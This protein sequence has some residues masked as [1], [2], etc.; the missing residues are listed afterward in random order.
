MKKIIIILAVFSILTVITQI[1]GIVYLLSFVISYKWKTELRFKKLFIF[2]SLYLFATF[3][4]V[5]YL[6]EFFG[7]ERIKH[8]EKIRPTNY[9]TVLLNRN[10]VT[11]KLNNLLISTQKKLKNTDIVISYLDANFPFVKGFSLLPHL[12]HNDGRKID[13]SFIYETKEGKITNKQK[14]ISGY[15]VFEAPKPNEINQPEICRKQGKWQYDKTKYLTFGKINKDLIFSEKGTKKLI[16]S[17]LKNNDLQKIF[18]EPHLKNRLK[19][20][21]SKVKY[22]GSWSVRHDDHIHIQVK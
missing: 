3:L 16:I 21:H 11:P 4:I 2:L 9:M 13:L 6:A 5:P 8:T 19:L 10:Y 22:Q 1:G 15:G 17:I 18:I 20:Y 12:S 14:S 7:R